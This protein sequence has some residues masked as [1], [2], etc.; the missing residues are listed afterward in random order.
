MFSNRNSKQ[1]KKNVS[2]IH[3]P[4]IPPPAKTSSLKKL[5]L[6]TPKKHEKKK[7]IIITSA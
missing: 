7:V 2:E 1:S 6:E 4:W 5:N 3:R